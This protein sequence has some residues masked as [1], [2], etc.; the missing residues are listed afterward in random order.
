MTISFVV[1]G[2][3]LVMALRRVVVWVFAAVA[4]VFGWVLR[5]RRWITTATQQEEKRGCREYADG[6]FHGFHSGIMVSF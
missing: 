4:L 6:R 3:R 5:R 1:L 2:L